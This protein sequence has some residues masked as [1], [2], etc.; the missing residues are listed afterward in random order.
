M[1]FPDVDCMQGISPGSE[2]VKRIRSAVWFGSGSWQGRWKIKP[3]LNR[4]KKQTGES[5]CTTAEK[6]GDWAKMLRSSGLSGSSSKGA[7]W[8]RGFGRS[9]GLPGNRELPIAFI[10]HLSL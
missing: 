8:P 7:L 3:V 10:F 2:G 5:G 6:L 9:L 1:V 4:K